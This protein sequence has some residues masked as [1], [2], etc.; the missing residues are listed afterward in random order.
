[1][2]GVAH[3]FAMEIGLRVEDPTCDEVPLDFREPDLNPVEPRGIGRGIM[4]L[5]VG[6]GAQ[7][8]F[9]RFGFITERLSAMIWIGISAG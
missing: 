1:M 9:D 8:G 3:D 4:E 2:A 5:D 7:E 6:M